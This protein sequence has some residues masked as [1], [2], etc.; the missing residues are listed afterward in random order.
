MPAALAIVWS[1]V[2]I[3]STVISRVIYGL[4]R[5]VREARQLG[6]YVIEH[7]IGEGGM[8]EVYRARHGMM[9]RPTALKLLRSGISSETA[10]ARFEREVAASVCRR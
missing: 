3:T 4:R 8:G 10:L 9:R 6:Q 1:I 5:E 7:K 2:V